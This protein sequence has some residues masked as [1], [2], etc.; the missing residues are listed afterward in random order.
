MTT[1]PGIFDHASWAGTSRG[2]SGGGASQ[3]DIDTIIRAL[4]GK[5]V[6]TQVMARCPVHDDRHPSLSI[7]IKDGNIL[8]HCFAGCKQTDVVAALRSR[9]LWPQGLWPQRRE[10][11]GLAVEV[12]DVAKIGKIIA[13]YDYVDLQG[14]IR[15]RVCRFEPK[16]FRPR[17]PDGQ[18][19]WLAPGPADEDKVLYRLPELIEAPI[20]FVAEG[21]K[22]VETL[23]EY[24]FIA[25]TN[26]GG[27]KKPWLPQYTAALAGREVILLPHNDQPRRAHMQNV[28]RAWLGN[29]AKL[30]YLELQGAKDITERISKG[31]SEVELCQL[32]SPDE[33]SE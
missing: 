16:D 18:G 14:E 6:G 12:G 33:E 10:C 2:N 22:D 27:A 19:G 17:V 24:G 13:T 3:T 4:A 31:H 8:L 20:V 5:R 26:I 21:E 11:S 25:T 1:T 30:R 23:C 15:Y 9:G 28:A 29:V 7:T 32:V